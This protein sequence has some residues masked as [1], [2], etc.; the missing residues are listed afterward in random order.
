[1]QPGQQIILHS[2]GQMILKSDVDLDDVVAWKEGFFSFNN[3][4]L[5]SVM[6]KLSRWYN[7]HVVYQQGVNNDQKFSGRIDRDLT[8]SQILNGLKQTKAHFKIESNRTVVI[9]P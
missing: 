4:N 2:D 1:M 6:R 9:L 3:E 7:I 8:L 5:T